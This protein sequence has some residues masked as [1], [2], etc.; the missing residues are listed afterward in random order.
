VEKEY[1]PLKTLRRDRKSEKRQEA[2]KRK[3][4]RDKI[5]PIRDKLNNLEERITA[6]ETREKELEKILSDPTVFADTEKAPAILTEYRNIRDK[7]KGLL[8]RWEY[9]QEQLEKTKN[10][11]GIE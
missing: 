5:K 8:A 4:I 10:G 7:I 2:E 11:L 6:L 3:E 9:E 1:T